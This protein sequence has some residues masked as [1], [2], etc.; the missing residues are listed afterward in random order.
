MIPVL[1]RE[2]DSC[3]LGY[4]FVPVSVYLATYLTFI[5]T[6]C[7]ENSVRYLTEIACPGLTKCWML[8]KLLHCLHF[9]DEKLR[10]EASGLGI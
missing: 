4:F 9:A 1:Q 3:S 5:L 8:P 7:L 6:G 2:V 10:Q